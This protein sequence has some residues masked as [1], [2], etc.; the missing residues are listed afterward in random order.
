MTYAWKGGGL[1]CCDG[2]MSFLFKVVKGDY[3]EATGVIMAIEKLSSNTQL[4]AVSIIMIYR[5]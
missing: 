2:L 5:K 1:S 3:L 4:I